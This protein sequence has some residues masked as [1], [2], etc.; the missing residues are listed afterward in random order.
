[1]Q[2][3]A[4]RARRLLS[5]V[6]CGISFGKCFR[7]ERIAYGNGQENI[8]GNRR[9]GGRRQ[10]PN[11]LRLHQGPARSILSAPGYALEDALWKKFG[12]TEKTFIPEDFFPPDYI[13]THRAK[14]GKPRKL[15]SIIYGPSPTHRL[16]ACDEEF[17]AFLKIYLTDVGYYTLAFF[18]VFAPYGE[19][20]DRISGRNEYRLIDH[21]ELYIE[22]YGC[23][24]D[25]L[26]IFSRHDAVIADLAAKFA[27]EDF[28]A[29]RCMADDSRNAEAEHEFDSFPK[30]I[31]QT[32]IPKP[33]PDFDWNRYHAKTD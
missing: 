23:D 4:S 12:V 5:S 18:N 32:H 33:N 2:A 7:V 1:M 21:C 31:S 26:N 19:L 28:Q 15:F 8:S 3:E 10:L 20:Y 13:A 6:I 27:E 24:G 14:S 16:A 17:H 22:T 9:G 30:K 25:Y 29:C 11:S